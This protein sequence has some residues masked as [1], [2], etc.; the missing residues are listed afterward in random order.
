MFC[1][2]SPPTTEALLPRNRLADTAGFEPRVHCSVKGK[3]IAIEVEAWRPLG[4]YPRQ[5]NRT[6]GPRGRRIKW[7]ADLCIALNLSPSGEQVKS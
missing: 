4:R 3:G 1:L 7:G 5:T 2:G 6:F